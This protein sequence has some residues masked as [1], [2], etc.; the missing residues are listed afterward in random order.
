MPAKPWL[1]S[2]DLLVKIVIT[3]VVFLIWGSEKERLAIQEE[4]VKIQREQAA[5]E[6]TLAESA[7]VKQEMNLAI[8]DKLITILSGL[9]QQC[10]SEDRHMFVD[11]LIDVN[12]AY[13]KV[14]FPY[15]AKET[16]FAAHKNCGGKD[17]PTVDQASYAAIKPTVAEKV[18]QLPAGTESPDGYVALGVFD[19]NQKAYRNFRIASGASDDG[20]AKDGTI[21]KANWSVYLRANTEN[22]EGGANPSLGI[23]PEGGCVRILERRDNIRG[24]TWAAV[25]LAKCA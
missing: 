6:Q 24:Q 19:K 25:K 15:G 14:P 7:K 5:T 22:T 1:E 12:D 21:M 23:I 13:S 16:I 10:L 18:E 11:Y 2:L 3:V 20:L 9:E 8:V 17:L 4:Q